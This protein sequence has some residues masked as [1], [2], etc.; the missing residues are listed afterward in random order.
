MMKIEVWSD[1]LCP[2][3]FIGKRKLELAIEELP[4]L[5]EVE[6]N[7][8]SFE[9]DPNAPMYAGVSIDEAIAKKYGVSVEQAKANNK[10]IVQAA[11]EVGLN[12]DFE[13]M[14][15]TNSLDAH[16]LTKLAKSKG[17]EDKMVNLLYRAYFEDGALISD[18]DVLMDLGL[19]VGLNQEDMMRVL[20]NQSEYL[21]EVRADENEASQHGITS[22]PYFVFNDKYAV[23]G[24]Q[25]IELFKKALT[26]FYAEQQHIKV[27][28]IPGMM[29]DDTG[30]EIPK[31]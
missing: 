26:D 15:P 28:E 25:P 11:K 3:C 10:N 5:E 7:F 8:K 24:A 29:C 2:F 22:V 16:R 23:K 20:N 1:F 31:R 6:L 21:Q 13:N 19:A 9:L 17:L 27:E 4:F 30:C 14:K 12:F 18:H